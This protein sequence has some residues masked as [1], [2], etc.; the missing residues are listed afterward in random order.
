MQIIEHTSTR[1]VLRYRRRLMAVF[2]ALFT[3]MSAVIVVMLFFQGAAMLSSNFALWR[4]VAWIGWLG[5]GSLFVGLGV[6][7]WVNT[8]RGTLCIFDKQA[9][10]VTVRRPR[11]LR[12]VEVIHSI[13]GVSHFDFQQ[14]DEVRAVA[15][16]MV[17]RSG[18]TILLA[19]VP[20]YDADLVYDVTRQA[21]AFLRS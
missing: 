1:L 6:I 13:Y 9:E 19:S 2:V 12:M 15:V 5:L 7:S 10:T 4:L 3:L 14:N 8:A 20:T 16:Y 18:E 11:W 17:L 21:R